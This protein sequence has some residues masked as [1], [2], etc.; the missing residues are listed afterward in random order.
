MNKHTAALMLMAITTLAQAHIGQGLPGS[1]H[2][3]PEDLLFFAGLALVVAA[4]VWLARR[5][6]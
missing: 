3:H 2:W 5:N 1:A 6:R 4:G